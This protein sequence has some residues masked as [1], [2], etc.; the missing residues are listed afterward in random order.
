[1]IKQI[2]RK[3]LNLLVNMII[4][5]SNQLRVILFVRIAILKSKIQL[6]AF[7][8][9]ATLLT[10]VRSA[11]NVLIKTNIEA[12]NFLIKFNIFQQLVN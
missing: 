12:F 8:T 4:K 9:F 3:T 5:F 11:V 6:R 1:M 2:R 7:V 10:F